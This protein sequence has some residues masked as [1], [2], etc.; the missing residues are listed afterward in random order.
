MH[1]HKPGEGTKLLLKM[2]A[3]GNT[4]HFPFG[5]LVFTCDIF[6]CQKG[7]ELYETYCEIFSNDFT[8]ILRCSS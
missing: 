8:F 7:E 2:H 4:V 6:F 5:S 1:F 3:T